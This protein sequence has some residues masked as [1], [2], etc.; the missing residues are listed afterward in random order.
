MGML[1]T[2][3]SILREKDFWVAKILCSIFDQEQMVS[4]QMSLS[5]GILSNKRWK[6]IL[7]NLVIS[8]LLYYPFFKAWERILVARQEAEAQ[9][10][11]NRATVQA[12]VHVRAVT[13]EG[14]RS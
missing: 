1:F 10:E 7:V 11:K 13:K 4:F 14:S 6:F 5:S 9:Q 12:E 2:S 3:L 8:A